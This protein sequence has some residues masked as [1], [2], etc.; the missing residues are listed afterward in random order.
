MSGEPCARCGVHIAYCECP[1]YGE[2]D[3]DADGN[4]VFVPGIV[5]LALTRRTAL[6]REAARAIEMS[7]SD[8][9]VAYGSCRAV[10]DLDDLAARIRKE[11]GE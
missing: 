2:E 9:K 7:S 8:I 1:P 11:L 5:D 10:T 4:P 6:L 3:E